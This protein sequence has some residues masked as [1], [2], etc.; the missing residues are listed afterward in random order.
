MKNVMLA[1]LVLLSGVSTSVCADWVKIYS[2]DKMTAYGDPTT[3]RVRG[4]ISKISSMFDFKTEAALA[5]G[6]TYN[7]VV[8][9][10]EFNCRENLQRMMGYSIFSGKM[11]KGKVL[12]IGA[13]A[14]DWKPVSKLKVA[15]D[16]KDYACNSDS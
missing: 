4:N 8:R 7:S 6:N 12:D 5:D 13:D 10:T 1:S 3:L 2:N 9:D 11:A 14:Q 16:M 15:I